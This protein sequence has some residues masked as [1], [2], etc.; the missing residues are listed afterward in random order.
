MTWCL[1]PPY[2]E[3]LDKLEEA[4]GKMPQIYEFDPG[5]ADGIRHSNLDAGGRVLNEFIP[6]RGASG[7]AKM[8]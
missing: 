1:T 7:I 4:A 3:F 6:A 5:H 2:P 8:L